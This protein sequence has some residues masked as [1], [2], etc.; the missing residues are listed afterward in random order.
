MCGNIVWSW[1]RSF[2][3]PESFCMRPPIAGRPL[4]V[5]AFRRSWS[6]RELPDLDWCQ[7]SG[8]RPANR[9]AGNQLKAWSGGLFGVSFSVSFVISVL[10]WD[11]GRGED[12]VRK[13]AARPELIRRTEGGRTFFFMFKD[14]RSGRT[15]ASRK[16]QRFPL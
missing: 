16:P 3:L 9:S 15:G 13:G 6:E 8:T 11:F 1:G 5:P 12:G 4:R 2:D 10:G 14:K 7:Q